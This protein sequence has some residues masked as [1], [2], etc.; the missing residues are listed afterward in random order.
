MQYVRE[1]ETKVRRYQTEERHSDLK[2]FAVGFMAGATTMAAIAG[3]LNTGI[4]R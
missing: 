2:W 4:L 3:I 1:L